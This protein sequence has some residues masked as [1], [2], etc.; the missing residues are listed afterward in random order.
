MRQKK[1]NAHCLPG[2]CSLSQLHAEC[3]TFF[4]SKMFINKEC[5]SLGVLNSLQGGLSAYAAHP[6]LAFEIQKWLSFCLIVFVLVGV[7]GLL[8]G[9]L[10][11]LPVW[12]TLRIHMLSWI[13]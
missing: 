1:K 12:W 3:C 13:N 7:S 8:M 4:P 11:D 2:K 6:P 10:V 5:A 9:W